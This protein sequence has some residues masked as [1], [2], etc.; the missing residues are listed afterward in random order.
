[1]KNNTRPDILGDAN[2]QKGIEHILNY[3]T[4]TELSDKKYMKALSNSNFAFGV[5]CNESTDK[6]RS[7]LEN[8][9]I[10]IFDISEVTNTDMLLTMLCN[11]CIAISDE[12]INSGKLD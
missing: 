2:I 11:I 10:R 7:C 5:M 3:L 9:L 6:V 8:E 12:Y 4:G 1:M